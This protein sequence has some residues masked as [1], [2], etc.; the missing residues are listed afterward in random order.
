MERMHSK[1]FLVP[2]RAER[3]VIVAYTG[4]QRGK[5]KRTTHLSKWN[6]I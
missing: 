1:P 4:N 3:L 2:S 5:E 6:L